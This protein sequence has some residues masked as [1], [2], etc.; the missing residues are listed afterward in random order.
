MDPHA[1][2]PQDISDKDLAATHEH[3]ADS[4]SYGFVASP[5]LV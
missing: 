5:C 1:I 2:H 3:A 4:L